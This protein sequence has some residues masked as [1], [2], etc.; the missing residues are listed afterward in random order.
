MTG[1]SIPVTSG[2]RL[3][4]VF[5]ITASGVTVVNTMPGYVSAGVGIA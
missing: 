4:L 2:T 1:L 5:G 3:L